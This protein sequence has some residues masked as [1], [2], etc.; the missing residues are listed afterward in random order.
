MSTSTLPGTVQHAAPGSKGFDCDTIL[1]A[2]LAQTFKNGGY[3][4]CVRY[5]SLGQGQNS[6]DLSFSEA[7]AILHAGLALSAVQHV[8]MPGWSP[9]AQLGTQYGSN[10]AANAASI[11]LPK[12]MNLWCDLEGIGAGTAASDVIGYCN[13]WYNAV[14][15]AGYIPGIYVGANCVLSGQQLYSDLNFQHYWK[16]EST[17][18]DIPNRG[19]QMVQG[20]VP[21]PVFGI[22]IDS[23]YTQN[24]QQGGAV[25]WLKI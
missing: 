22:G 17:V 13:A 3:D 8:R 16:S 19:Y 10:A 11:G 15:A 7:N 4:F 23:D 24:D 25:V 12:G 18:P 20:Y 6:G 21:Q 1:S 2:Q 14:S 9:N 5:L